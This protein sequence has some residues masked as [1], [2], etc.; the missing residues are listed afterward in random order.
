MLWIM[1]IIALCSLP[2]FVMTAMAV[3]VAGWLM[4]LAIPLYIFVHYAGPRI[5][6]LDDARELQNLLE[7]K[8]D[9]PEAGAPGGLTKDFVQ[10]PSG[11][12]EKLARIEDAQIQR[13]RAEAIEA[14]AEEKPAYSLL[15][16]RTVLSDTSKLDWETRLRVESRSSKL[17]AD[18]NPP[19]AIREPGGRTWHLPVPGTTVEILYVVDKDAQRVELMSLGSIEQEVPSLGE[20]GTPHA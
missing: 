7:H 2:M 12:F 20:G 11:D 1:M 5:E 19:E 3:P 16:S 13:R 8:A 15:K 6:L 17:A 9:A 18:P 10:I 4:P 14:V